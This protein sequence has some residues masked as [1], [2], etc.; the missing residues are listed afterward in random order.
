MQTQRRTLLKTTNK[1]YKQGMRIQSKIVDTDYRL[2]A[3]NELVPIVSG[4]T[5]GGTGG[6]PDP[7]WQ[8]KSK[9]WAPFS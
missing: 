1:L 5:D 7:P 6:R 9:N 8:A 3:D 2:F 4:V